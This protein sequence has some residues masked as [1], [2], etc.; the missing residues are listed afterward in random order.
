MASTKVTTALF[1]GSTL[2]AAAVDTHSS[3]IDLT[4]GYGG[5]LHAKLTN[6]ASGPT[7]AAQVQIRVS[8]DGA[9]WYD[10][11]GALVGGTGNAGIYDWG[12]IPIDIGIEHAYVAGGSNTGEDVTADVD[13]TE[14]TALT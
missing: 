11:G 6:G 10:L 8:G 5:A 4:D 2:T 7:V 1:N 14:V 13:I 12:G 3:T 9:E